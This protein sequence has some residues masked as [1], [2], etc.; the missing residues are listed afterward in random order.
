MPLG[1]LSKKHIQQAYEVLTKLQNNLTKG[2]KTVDERTLIS[3][4][5][6]F[7]SLIPHDYGVDQPP[8]LDDGDL[9]K[10]RGASES[11]S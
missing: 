6:Q 1:K 2:G 9:I 10:V 4:T 3:F 7:F 11:W 5:N 8:L